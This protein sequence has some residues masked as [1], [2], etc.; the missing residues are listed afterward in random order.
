MRDFIAKIWEVNPE[1][2]LDHCLI[3]SESIFAETFPGVLKN[4]LDE[5]IKINFV[6]PQ[7]LNSRFIFEFLLGIGM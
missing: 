3:Y 1:I 6:E 7:L 5:V 2:A 4:M